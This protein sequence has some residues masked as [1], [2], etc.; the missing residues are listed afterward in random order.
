MKPAGSE[1]RRV[2]CPKITWKRFAISEAKAQG[3]YWSE[4]CAL[5]EYLYVIDMYNK[6][7][8]LILYWYSIIRKI[9]KKSENIA[10]LKSNYIHFPNSYV[11]CTQLKYKLC[12]S[13][14]WQFVTHCTRIWSSYPPLICFVHSN[15]GNL[16][17]SCGAHTRVHTRLIPL[18]VWIA[19]AHC[20]GAADHTCCEHSA[21]AWDETWLRPINTLHMHANGLLIQYK[22][23][24][25]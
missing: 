12:C 9:Q 21:P 8:Q 3:K 25:N 17:A 4:L 23:K 22:I 7:S 15:A 14:L 16:P 13:S 20:D 18:F 24:W 10:Y 2:K 6:I 5:A 19:V 11:I 1:G